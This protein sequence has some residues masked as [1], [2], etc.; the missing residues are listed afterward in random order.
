MNR[1][2]SSRAYIREIRTFVT[3]SI[4]IHHLTL[5][6]VGPKEMPAGR[7]EGVLGQRRAAR[8]DGPDPNA[9]VPCEDYWRSGG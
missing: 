6:I 9:D 3:S 8:G 7:L 5:Q 1:I 4:T 2:E